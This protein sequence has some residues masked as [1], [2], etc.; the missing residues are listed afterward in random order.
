[1]APWRDRWL[2][3]RE[4][5]L[6]SARFQQRAA[7]FA[8]T[9]PI[10]R[11]RAR[12]TFDLVAGFVYSQVL[13]AC[14][15]LGLLDRLAGQ[16]QEPAQIARALDLSPDAA[17][18]LLD[19]AVSLRLLERRSGGRIGLGV[20][21]APL[22]GNA[23]LQALVD[24]HGAFYADLGDP[25]A[26]LRGGTTGSSNLSRLWAYAEA[27]DAPAGLPADR[28][29]AYSALMAASQPLVAQQVLDA[30]PMRG[31]RCVL[32]V[33]GGEGGFLAQAAQRWPELRVML[34]DLPAVADAARAR[35]RVLG[36][37]ARSSAI[38]GDFFRDAL[39][40]GADLATLVRVVHDHD[41]DRA[42]ALLRAVRRALPAHG[43]ILLAEPMAHTR[44]AEPVG[45]AYFNFY[46]LAMGQGRARS[47]ADLAGLLKAAGFDAPQVIPT[48]LPLQ[49]SLLVARCK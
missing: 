11:R 15:R 20:L 5:W 1:M 21:G 46:L 18:R 6:R 35:F 28:V 30:Y 7:A 31:H 34:F 43:R 27:Q 47:A 8:L 16:P 37:Q 10:A 39:P 45:D 44:G 24:H 3:W 32:D 49:S 42:L 17:Q 40:D 19:A 4:Q 33:G 48:A 14:V 13:L 22:A 36:L 26:L 23:A 38:G 29:A 9:R 25:V 2:A 12:A 41:D